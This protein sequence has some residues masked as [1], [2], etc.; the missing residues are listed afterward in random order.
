MPSVTDSACIVIKEMQGIVLLCSV[1][2]YKI[3]GTASHSLS[4][5]NCRRFLCDLEDHWNPEHYTLS[6]DY[7]SGVVY[8]KKEK[9]CERMII[10]IAIMQTVLFNVTPPFRKELECDHE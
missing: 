3:K 2:R 4:V 5:N 9:S 1:A 8:N 6:L 10:I 7:K